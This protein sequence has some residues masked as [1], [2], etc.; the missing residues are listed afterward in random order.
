MENT[1]HLSPNHKEK[2]L[3]FQALVLKWQK[4]INLIGKATVGD[5][6][7][8]HI[9]D[10]LQ[11]DKYL[12]QKTTILD[13]GSG[14]GFPG[15]VLS[16]I[17]HKVTMVESDHRKAIFLQEAIRQLG[18]DATVLIERV[19]ELNTDVLPE[20]GYITARAFAPLDRMLEWIKPFFKK[21]PTLVLLKGQT[22]KEEIEK[23]RKAVIFDCETAKSTTNPH[24]HILTLKGLK[25]KNAPR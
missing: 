4:K 15:I 25:T 5:V 1:P 20:N 6:W 17:G 18:L 2:L 14:G 16:V 22:A 9:L 23:A 13:L 7:E 12:P 3:A 10:S 11:L 19:E 21:N 8:R 24:G